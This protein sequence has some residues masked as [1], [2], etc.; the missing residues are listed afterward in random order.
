[1]LIRWLNRPAVIT[2]RPRGTDASGSLACGR[3]AAASALSTRESMPRH[4]PVTPAGL[5]CGL[6]VATSN[7]SGFWSGA[8][9]RSSAGTAMRSRT[10]QRRMA[11]LAGSMLHEDVVAFLRASSRSSIIQAT[12]VALALGIRL[13]PYEV[14]AQI[15]VGGMGEVYRARDSKLNRDVALKVLPEAFAADADRLARFKREA[16]VLA[17]LNHPHIAAIYGFEDSGS[18]HALVLELVEGPTLADR[19]ARGPLAVDEALA[20]AKQIAEALE[21]AHGQGIIH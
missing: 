17:S 15:G 10:S 18:T 1:M 3:N 8:W 6:I 7:A 21:A 11:N 12:S 19:I 20:V 14:V 13:G 2:H 16:Q 4:P 9:P 5:R